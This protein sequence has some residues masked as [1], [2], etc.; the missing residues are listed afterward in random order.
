MK[1]F[2]SLGLV[3]V[4]L[5][6]VGFVTQRSDLA[7]ML[8]GTAT[9][10]LS[11]GRANSASTGTMVDMASYSGTA[12][13]VLVGQSD[14]TSGVIYMVIQDSSAGAAAVTVD[15]F[16]LDSTDNKYYDF[17]YRGSR[18]WIRALQ[19]ASGSAADTVGSAA[20]VVQSG[21]RAR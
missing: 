3:V 17:N 12:V 19:R 1:R 11:G 4:L 6:L 10:A 21:K 16:A 14:L 8:D 7:S 20:I 13:Q 2:G 18:R 9:L 5:G 15:S